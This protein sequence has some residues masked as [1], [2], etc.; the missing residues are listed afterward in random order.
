METFILWAN[1][2]KT[3]EETKNLQNICSVA[4]L[5][6]CRESS[7]TVSLQE[8]Q[9][10]SFIL[11][12]SFLKDRHC[13]RHTYV[14]M[15]D[16]PLSLRVSSNKYCSESCQGCQSRANTK[17]FFQLYCSLE[18][19]AFENVLLKLAWE[20]ILIIKESCNKG[21]GRFYK[22][23][24]KMQMY[25]KHLWLLIAIMSYVYYYFLKFI[26]M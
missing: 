5:I 10:S 14:Y 15:L 1:R 4:I 12:Y 8:D 21:N 9:I 13:V 24:T 6:C 25:K 19:A 7:R 23:C 22:N 16:T 18:T 17:R 20:I 3:L 26:L 2:E 11:K